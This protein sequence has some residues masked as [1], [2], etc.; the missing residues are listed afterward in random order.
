MQPD[1]LQSSGISRRGFLRTALFGGTGLALAACGAELDA[2]T[3]AITPTP[4]PTATPVP[5]GPKAIAGDVLDYGFDSSSWPGD[6]GWVTLRLH[7]ARYDG[8]PVYYI[9][10]DA[11]DEAFARQEGLVWMPLL[12]AGKEAEF[13]NKLY[14]FSDGRP[15]VMRSIPGQE[16]YLSL[17]EIVRVLGGENLEL[18]SLSQLQAAG[19]S[20]SIALEATGLFVNYPVLKWPGGELPVD[21]ARDSYLGTGQLLEP[22]DLDAMRVTIKLHEGFPS[23]WYI[24]TH[25]SAIDR[26]ADMH[27]APAASS[28]NTTQY[29]AAD[30]LFVFANGI[31]GS[32]VLGYQ[33]AVFGSSVASR[34]SSPFWN[35]FTVRW[36]F[37]EH[38]RVLTNSGDVYQ[39]IERGELIKFNGLPETHPNGFVVNCPVVVLADNR[40]S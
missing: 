4:G 11:S 35:H 5:S 29:N 7:E 9:R 18:T 33:P 12:V 2:A 26:A 23:S 13:E 34:V 14:V 39:A 22:M 40:L 27:I 20:G 37:E 24:V 3:P 19:E 38:A 15:P 8:Q 32:G 16:P 1:Q 31:P 21:Q 6:F 28:W 25:T 10:T 17:F 36:K 30:E